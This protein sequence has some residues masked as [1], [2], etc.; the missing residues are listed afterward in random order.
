MTAVQVARSRAP[1]GKRQPTASGSSLGATSIVTV[2]SMPRK[3]E[4]R[5]M[6]TILV[7]G[8]GLP[9]VDRG[10]RGQYDHDGGHGRP[11]GE[12]RPHAQ[13][14]HKGRPDE[15]IGDPPALQHG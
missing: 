14:D 6:I 8:D 1:P 11:S 15:A 4:G 2:P 5:Y 13:R 12:R 10:D 3:R 7:S 9:M